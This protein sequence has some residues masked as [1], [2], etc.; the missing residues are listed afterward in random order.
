MFAQ[1]LLPEISFAIITSCSICFESPITD[2]YGCVNFPLLNEAIRNIEK[3]TALSAKEL[4]L[5]LFWFD[6]IEQVSQVDVRG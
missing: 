3:T 5:L 1:N 4:L 2:L 6:N